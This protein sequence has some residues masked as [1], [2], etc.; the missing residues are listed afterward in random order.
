M[1][2]T[3]KMIHRMIRTLSLE[4]MHDLANWLQAEIM[5]V[6]LE[7]IPVRPGREVV[8][9]RKGGGKTYRLEKIKCGKANCKCASGELH[10][11]Y[12][13]AYYR[14]NGKLK[15]EYIGKQLPDQVDREL[16]D[17]P[18][19]QVLRRIGAETLPGLS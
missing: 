17:K 3:I 5:I 12:W 7:D 18:P 2:S 16:R 8:E 13:Y 9:T 14:V 19:D 11:P 1:E 10:G 4:D 6:S 15:S